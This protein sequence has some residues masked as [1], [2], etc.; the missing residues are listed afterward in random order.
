[1]IH[2]VPDMVY[3]CLFNRYPKSEVERFW[4]MVCLAQFHDVLPGS[5]I[6]MVYDD[7]MRVSHSIQYL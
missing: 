1:M 6:E 2:N 5:A 7:V 3:Q 4:K